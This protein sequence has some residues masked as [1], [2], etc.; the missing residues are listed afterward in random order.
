MSRK[1]TKP[2]IE[3]IP[4]YTEKQ[5]QFL[6]SEISKDKLDGRFFRYLAIHAEKIG[7]KEVLKLAQEELEARKADFKERQLDSARKRSKYLLH[8]EIPPLIKTKSNIY[9]E[10]EMNIITGKTPLEK[11]HTTTISRICSKAQANKDTKVF[12]EFYA[13]Y[14]DRIAASAEKHR[15][16][17]YSLRM[18]ETDGS[19]ESKE[20]YEKRTELTNWEERLLSGN[21]TTLECSIDHMKH[22]V[23]VVSDKNDVEKTRTALMMLDYM[24]HPDEKVL[25][26]DTKE[27]ALKLIDLVTGLNLFSDE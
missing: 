1:R 21:V 16:H 24:E 2:L 20:Q 10:K 18:R 4:G 22:V 3:T 17:F 26:C 11:V 14:I 23:K 6:R 5:S 7:D 25:S 27:E 15:N 9:T 8:G 19:G 12:D 13:I